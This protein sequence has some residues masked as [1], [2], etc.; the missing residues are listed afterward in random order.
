MKVK[1]KTK[2]IRSIYSKLSSMKVT[3]KYAPITALFFFIMLFTACEK[4]YETDL[5]NSI[6]E[7]DFYKN[8]SEYRAAIMGLYSLQQDLAEQLIVLGELR[9]DLLKITDNADRDLREIYHFNVSPNNKYASPRGF[10][11]L[12]AACNSFIRK[13]E[14]YHP[15]VLDKS[16]PVSNYDKYYGEALCMRAWAYFNA[17]RI[18][19]KIPYIPTSVTGISEIITYVNSP[20]TVYDSIDII[21]APDGY[22]NDTIYRDTPVEMD[23]AYL[24]L[25]AI[26]DTLAYQ[27]KTKIKAIGVNHHVINGD[28]TWDATIWS[29]YGLDALLGHMYLTIG[30][31]QQAWQAFEP[32]VVNYEGTDNVKFGL[33][34][35]FANTNWRNIIT[36]INPDEHIMVLKF[37]KGDRQRNEL[38]YLFSNEGTNSFQMQPTSTA[39][40]AWETIWD[41]F[42]LIP[43]AENPDKLILDPEKP[44][45]PGDFYRG[46]G[47]SY[48]YSRG[49]GTLTN[50]E[51][52]QML[53]NKRL[54]NVQEVE[55]IMDG[56]DTVV[57]KYS[58]GK[59]P[60]DHDANVI[61][62]RAA[63]IHLYVAEAFTNGL[64]ASPNG[65]P[66]SRVIMA[67]QFLNNGAYNFNNK[68]LG[69]RGRVGF[70][71]GYENIT[72][73]ESIWIR[74]PFT[75]KV[76]YKETWSGGLP[77]KRVYL[78]DMILEE[79]ARE[80]AFEG[81]RFYDL[82]RIAKR[83]GDNS[84]LANRV[85]SKFQGAEKEMIRQL[86]MNEENWYIPFSLGN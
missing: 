79:R 15:E 1:M 21:Y 37:N 57:Y 78:E 50:E 28:I 86:L 22:N 53:E 68:Q 32:I 14:H 84:Y 35:R 69:V 7:E 17:V 9:A 45:D 76:L 42:N 44:G 41:N 47:I 2:T 62:Y 27:L 63:G 24:D 48:A 85:A 13:M 80:L 23:N 67:Q 72:V 59:N 83:R 18:Y 19:G 26:V 34:N 66:R 6:R 5:G 71:D 33:D 58:L 55:R 31:L 29:E 40:F 54:G 12:I 49:A 52:E 60:F 10:Y 51:V 73:D 46:H 11:T 20:K 56:A 25:N 61:I 43:S 30:D 70:D 82:M 65:T 81:E 3:F 4:F 75:N 77:E 39:I 8:Q 36:G 16:A 38:Q 64:F 74:D